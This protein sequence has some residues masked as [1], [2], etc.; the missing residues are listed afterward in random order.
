M[1]GMLNDFIYG[2]IWLALVIA[3][4]FTGWRATHQG[5]FKAVSQ[6]YY[7]RNSQL[8]GGACL[9]VAII[10]G[11]FF[12]RQLLSIVLFGVLGGLGFLLGAALGAYLTLR[13]Y[14]RAV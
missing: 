8:M 7:G 14:V 9:A 13:Y 10:A 3:L 4:F 6:T 12:V 5:F 1:F 11:L 2:A